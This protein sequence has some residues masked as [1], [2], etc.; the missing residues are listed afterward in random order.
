MSAVIRAIF[1][2][3]VRLVVG[4]HPVWQGC[5]PEPR[6]RIYFANHSSHLDTLTIV[7][8]LPP[9]LRAQTHPVAALDY[10]GGTA[11]RRFIALQC[12]NAVLVDRNP[13][14][15]DPLEPLGE[16]LKAGQS[17]IIFPEGTRGEGAVTAFKSGLFHLARRFP[18]AELVPVYLDNLYRVMPK[19]SF[20]PLP[21]ICTPRIGAPMMLSAGETR[22]AFLGRARAALD[23]LVQSKR[24]GLKPQP[25]AA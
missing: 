1:L 18:E 9:V 13:R 25:L 7:A 16:L 15:H 23:G 24:L 21:L 17:L 20:L 10:W 19:G 2:G 6:L 4:A 14:A 11:L 3:L 5:A 12:L 22:D 8:A